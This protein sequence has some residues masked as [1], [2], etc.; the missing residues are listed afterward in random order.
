MASRKDAAGHPPC[1]VTATHLPWSPASRSCGQ[2]GAGGAQG[3]E[4]ATSDL[5][6][7]PSGE[8]GEEPGEHSGSHSLDVG[9]AACPHQH[10]H[11]G[12]VALWPGL[13]T[14][15]S[16]GSGL[17]GPGHPSASRGPRGGRP[18]G[19]RACADGGRVA[20]LSSGTPLTGLPDG[21]LIPGVQS[22]R[23]ISP[24]CSQAD[25]V[26]SFVIGP[27]LLGLFRGQS[28]CFI[29]HSPRRLPPATPAL[30]PRRVYGPHVL[31]A[32]V[33][34][35][36]DNRG[37]ETV[38]QKSRVRASAGPCHPRRVSPQL[39]SEAGP[40]VL[41]SAGGRTARGP[42]GAQCPRVTGFIPRPPR[43]AATTRGLA[44]IPCGT[45]GGRGRASRAEGGSRPH[46][47]AHTM[48]PHP[49]S[50]PQALAFGLC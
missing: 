17:P 9:M 12:H 30:P 16:R 38:P 23:A 20:P 21:I 41:L 1:G 42:S 22:P 33:P 40:L 19:R 45:T 26:P 2:G 29:C 37:S 15:C 35:T 46:V 10:A 13:P 27:V 31:T 5:R 34:T 3:G 6:P 47:G 14:G 11:R 48:Y 25:A 24:I 39:P 8:P 28:A 7:S 18:G 32:P 43:D 44:R 49:V 4:A 36:Q 50:G